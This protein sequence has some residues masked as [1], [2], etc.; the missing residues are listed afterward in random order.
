MYLYALQLVTD[1]VTEIG[2]SGHWN[3]PKKGFKASSARLFFILIFFH[4]KYLAKNEEKSCT[5]CLKKRFSTALP[6]P[7]TGFRYP[8]RDPS[9]IILLPDISYPLFFFS[10][11]GDNLMMG[12]RE[13]TDSVAFAILLPTSGSP[14]NQRRN[15]KSK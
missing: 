13:K 11:G 4:G 3:Q 6:K 15:I 5:T 7:A 8:I 10:S 9:L 14:N 2:Y 1:R 12:V